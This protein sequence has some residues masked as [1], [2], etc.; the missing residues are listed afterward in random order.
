MW[1]V[2]DAR[3][4]NDLSSG[5]QLV[6]IRRKVKENRGS[7]LATLLRHKIL[8]DTIQSYL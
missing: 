8:K 4:K 6:E 2:G 5:I 7:Q 3:T 1:C